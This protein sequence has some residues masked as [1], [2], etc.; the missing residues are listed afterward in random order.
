MRVKS[1]IL[2]QYRNY[3]EQSL[4]FSVG[5]NIILGKN[6]HGKTNLLEALYLLSHSRSHRTSS[7]REL[8]LAGSDYASIL[9]MMSPHAYEGDIRLEAQLRRDAAGRLKTVFKLNGTILKSRSKVLGHLPSVSFFNT[10]LSLLR[11]SPSDRRRWLDSTLVQYN[12]RHFSYVADYEKIR[13]QKSRL[14]KE[15]LKNGGRTNQE[16]LAVWNE[17][18]AVAASK[19]VESRLSY[20]QLIKDPATVSYLELSGRQEILDFNYKSE[21]DES[22]LNAG[23]QAVL[24]EAYTELLAQRFRDEQQ[25]GVCLVGPHRDDIQFSLN[26][27][28]ACAYGS[29]GQQ[30]TLVLALKLTELSLLNHVSGEAPILILDDVM[31]ELD[32]DRQQYL[33]DHIPEEIQ[34]FLSTTHLDSQLNPVVSR[35]VKERGDSAIFKVIEGCVQKETMQ[36]ELRVYD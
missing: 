13:K 10:D 23:G 28:D 3:D 6:G 29:Q 9:V 25:R 33:I 26:Q 20:L 34:V 27:L 24:Q 7:D 31:A 5:K 22:Y 12:K 8:L 35:Y 11:G 15:G 21:L 30:R 17:Q 36:K 2:R 32:P 16:H 1:L 19:L 18:L 4:G 14:L